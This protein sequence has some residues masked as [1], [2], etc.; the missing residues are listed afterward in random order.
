MISVFKLRDKKSPTFY[1]GVWSKIQSLPS[2][3]FPPAKQED[4]GSKTA[5]LQPFRAKKKCR[6]QLVCK[7][8]ENT[9][10][11]TERKTPSSSRTKK[12]DS[13]VE[14]AQ[15]FETALHFLTRLLTV[16]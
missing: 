14:N 2:Y 7:R 4:F 5:T 3:A 13:K 9:R 11:L 1:L 10:R 15:Q 6:V 16:K 12:F 8:N